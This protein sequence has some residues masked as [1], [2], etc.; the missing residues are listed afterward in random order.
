MTRHYDIAIAGSG[1]GGSLLSM[2]AHRLGHSVVLIERGTHP[3]TVIGESSTPL[4]NLL[5][6]ELTTRY[7]LPTIRPLSKWGTW[8]QAHPQIACGLKR[9]FTFYHHDLEDPQPFPPDR[10]HQLLVA[11]SPHDRIADT[12]WYRADFDHLLVREAQS[13]GVDYL[14]ETTLTKITEHDSAIQFEATRHNNPIT[15]SAKLL[16]DATGPRGLLHHALNLGEKPLPNLPHTQA[17][18]THFT[19]AGK[20]EPSHQAPP[21]PVDAAAVHHIFDGGWIWVLQFN[22]GITSAGIAATDALATKLNLSEG[23]PAWQRIL[24]HIPALQHQ[25]SDAKPTQPF[26]HIPHLSF[27]SAA[28]TGKRWALLPSA[29]GFVDPLLSTGFPLTLT[30][31]DRLARILNQSTDAQSFDSPSLAHELQTYAAETEADQ[32]AATRLIAALYANMHDFPTF[33]ALSLLYFAAVSYAETAHRLNKPELAPSFLL[34][35]HPTFGPASKSLCERALHIA[36]PAQAAELREDILGAI[37][38]IN[39]ASLGNATRRNWYP[40]DANDLI[41]AAPKLNASPEDIDQLLQRCG[42]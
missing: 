32:L 36:T 9:G 33:S 15:I 19:G 23:A 39:V 24:T 2:I 11:A 22:N 6:E 14:D 26:R 7:D 20:I 25:F 34:H 1:F 21:Y 5:L 16:I 42:F 13:L 8:Q 40:V 12:H 18:Y 3:R 4:T 28:I 35:T 29:A 37:D 41:Q 17:L 31:I 38:P 10:S 27:Q 30:G